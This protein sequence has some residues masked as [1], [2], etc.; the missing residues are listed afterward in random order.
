MKKIICYLL[1]LSAMC[2]GVTAQQKNNYSYRQLYPGYI[3]GL[4]NDTIRG[5]IE[6]GERE[7]NQT[8]CIF[9]TNAEDRKTKKI[10]KPSELKGYTM[11]DLHYRSVD[12]SGNIGFFK[13]QKSFLLI[14]TPGYVNS[15]VYYL[16]GEQLVWQRGDEA[17]IS[18]ASMLMGF[19][20][21]ILKL[22]GDDTELAAKIEKGEK[23]YGMLSI[24]T[25]IE[26]YNTWHASK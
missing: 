4:Q 22:V 7:T 10:Y 9:Y 20:K 15:Y 23:G 18:N 2:N 21:N 25:I 14:T 19:K 3:I 13:A 24:M 1:L 5:F 11:E 12:Y 8:K 16:D 17:P 6:Y 26:E